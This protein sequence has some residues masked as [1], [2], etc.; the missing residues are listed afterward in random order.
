MVANYSKPTK[1][2]NSRRLSAASALP[3]SPQVATLDTGNQAD[4]DAAILASLAQQEIVNERFDPS[5]WR[6]EVYTNRNGR[7]YWNHRRRG[8]RGGKEN[9]KFGGRFDGL[10]QERQEQYWQRTQSR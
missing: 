9:W 6:I 1:P 4:S 5:E 8:K 10:S 7:R 3:V 2:D